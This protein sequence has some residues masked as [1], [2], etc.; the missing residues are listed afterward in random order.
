MHPMNCW[1]RRKKPFLFDMRSRIIFPKGYSQN[2]SSHLSS[3]VKGVKNFW[4]HTI[5]LRFLEDL[6]NWMCG[7]PKPSQYYYIFK[8]VPIDTLF[9]VL[10][11]PQFDFHFTVLC[12]WV[13][14]VL[15]IFS[16]YVSSIIVKLRKGDCRILYIYVTL[17]CL[18]IHKAYKFVYWKTRVFVNRA[19][20][21]T[22]NVR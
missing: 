3:K 18:K 9:S 19:W 12:E 21:N 16:V 20:R 1:F 15:N 6:F 4:Q 7:I 22:C 17:N 13:Q 2:P 11:N 8:V 14:S 5:C 10:N